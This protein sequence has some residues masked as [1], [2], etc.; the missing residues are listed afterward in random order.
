MVS[1][2]NACSKQLC[3]LQCESVKFL[4]VKHNARGCL[5]YGKACG[6]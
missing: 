2:R 6:A 4:K 5:K 1:W 3:H